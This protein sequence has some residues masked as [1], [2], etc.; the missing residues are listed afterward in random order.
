MFTLDYRRLIK[1]LLPAAL[2]KEQMVLWLH[3]LLA[4]VMR[5]YLEF[6]RYRHLVNYRMEHTGQVIYL[7]K[8]LNERFDTA[9]K[10]IF[11][12]DGTK[13]DTINIF[14]TAE[15]KPKY[16]GKIYLYDHLAY[17]ETGADF[18][19]HIP[20]DIP[21]WTDSGLMAECRSLLNYYKLAGKRYKL[22]KE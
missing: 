11:I 14:L 3:A 18:Q 15:K 10:Q 4:P 12:D 13:Y 17:G 8:I 1:M 7:E 6:L 22:I 20:E 9:S 5:L 16:L 19:V 21:I 2:R